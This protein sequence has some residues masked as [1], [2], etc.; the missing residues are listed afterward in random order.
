[1][2]KIVDK[3]KSTKTG[4]SILGDI[5]YRIVLFATLT[6]VIN[7]L[8]AL[9]NLAIGIFQHSY[10]FITIGT[11]YTVLSFMRFAAVIFEKKKLADD[12][13]E[14]ELFVQKFSGIMLIALSVVLAGS[15]YMSVTFDVIS[16]IDE[17]VMISIAT[18]TFV[19]I[20]MAIIN[21]V[22][23]RKSDSPLIATLRNISLSDAAVSVLTM[24]R[25]ML[26][27]FE[28]MKEFDIKMMNGIVGTA[29][30]IFV[31]T[32]GISMIITSIKGE[33]NDKEST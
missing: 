26:V 13:N 5:R 24:Q 33:K 2:S 4:S 8:Y 6:L 32:L 23:G 15:V 1:M 3:L 22:K 10:W 30:Y 25:S 31:C 11:Y 27:T 29:V 17:I 14:S 20:I 12:K 19:K 7:M 18:F 28:G 21:V 9:G 16:R